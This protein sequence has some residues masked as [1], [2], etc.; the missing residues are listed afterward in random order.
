VDHIPKAVR[1]NVGEV[2]TS[3]DE[4]DVKDRML[5]DLD[6]E[7]VGGWLGWVGGVGFDGLVLM[8]LVLKW[9]WYGLKWVGGEGRRF[10]P[11]P[12]SSSSSSGTLKYRSRAS[13]A[14]AAARKPV[15]APTR[16]LVGPA[17]NQADPQTPRPRAGA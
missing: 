7:Q 9:G 15:H 11:R 1:G 5:K 17:S 2:L 3:K 12:G 6:L 8:G 13:G 16:I 10:E 4:R 14:A